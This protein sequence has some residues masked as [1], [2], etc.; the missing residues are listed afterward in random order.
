[1]TYKR[2]SESA[3]EECED[4]ENGGRETHIVCRVGTGKK[5]EDDRF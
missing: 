3:G 2:S 5:D 1:M 4:N